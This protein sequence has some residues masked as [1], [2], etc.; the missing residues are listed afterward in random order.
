M[1]NADK[2][3]FLAVIT[4]TW[5][6]YGKQVDRET[7]ADWWEMLAE[8]PLAV[9]ATAFNAH[10]RD[11]DAGQYLPKPADIFRHLEAAQTNSHPSPDEA[12]GLLMAFVSDEGN[13]SFLT[14]QMREAWRVCSSLLDMGDNIGARMC[15]LETYRKALKLASAQRTPPV[16]HVTLGTDAARRKPALQD[17]VARGYISAD[18]AQS[19][20]PAPVA[21]LEHLAGLLGHDGP[22]EPGQPSYA[23]RLR[24]L[25]V[26]AY[27]CHEDTDPVQA[28]QER[29][30]AIEA[31]KPPLEDCGEQSLRRAA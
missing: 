6:F 31:K 12:W 22:K 19:L 11:P 15:F 28:E 27:A 2:K 14:D 26:S 23:E 20:L 5:R 4:K 18:Y 10:L 8:F 9:I 1:D 21:S 16:W 3:D 17:A 24:A 29:H 25:I 13:T 7:V 30:A